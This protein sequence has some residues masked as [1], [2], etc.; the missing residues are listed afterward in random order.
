MLII[1]RVQVPLP[2]PKINGVTI[3]IGYIIA[4]IISFASGTLFGIAVMCIFSYSSK[5][6]DEAIILNNKH[7]EVKESEEN[8]IGKD[9][10]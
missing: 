7:K 6:G 5:I 4:L 1:V 2:P 9:R 10:N 8:N 3:V